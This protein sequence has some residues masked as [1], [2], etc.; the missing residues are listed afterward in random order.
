MELLV[1][2]VPAM[3]A[4]EVVVL[5]RVAVE[6]VVEVDPSMFVAWLVPFWL[7]EVCASSEQRSH[8][9]L[10]R[11][12]AVEDS[13]VELGLQHAIVDLLTFPCPT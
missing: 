8:R 7:V 5:A 10:T 2:V 1:Y 12:R 3:F 11:A 6:L 4:V 9:A 13:M